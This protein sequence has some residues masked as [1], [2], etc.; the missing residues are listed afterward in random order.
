MKILS[1]LSILFLIACNES[2]ETASTTSSD[3]S[4]TRVEQE[5]TVTKEPAVDTTADMLN[6]SVVDNKA[7]ERKKENGIAWLGIG[8]EPFW[9]VERKNDTLIFQMAD[10]DK[11]VLKVKANRAANSK[12]SVVY[13]GQNPEHKLQVSLLP[14]ECSDGMSDRK[15]D[16][17]VK[18]VHNGNIYKGCAVIF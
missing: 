13:I 10:W 15:Y 9:S 4:V 6:P 8:T 17:A 14:G 7:W 3:T 11:K 16:Y 1:L 18:V 5:E 12:D 2:S